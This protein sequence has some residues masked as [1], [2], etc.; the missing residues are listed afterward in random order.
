MCSVTLY[1]ASGVVV[2]N[3]ALQLNGVTIGGDIVFSPPV[4]MP[5]NSIWKLRVNI[6]SPD[7]VPDFFPSDLTVTYQLYYALAPVISPLF[8]VNDPQK[9]VGFD[10]IGFTLE[11]Y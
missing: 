10:E 3:T 8:V 1:T 9:G 7:G 11:V 4:A 2:P 5:I 6:S